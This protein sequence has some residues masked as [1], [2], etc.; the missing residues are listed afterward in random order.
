ML[1]HAD[2]RWSYNGFATVI[3]ANK[4]IRLVVVPSLGGKLLQLE[5]R[6]T[7]HEWLWQ[8][9]RIELEA[10]PIGAIFDHHWSGGADLFFPTCYPCTLHGVQIP[11]AGEMWNV[12]WQSTILSDEHGV[13]LV[14]QAG[15]RIFPYVAKRILRLEHDAQTISLHFE[16]CNIGHTPMPFVLGFHPALAVQP[17]QQIWLPPGS[18]EVLESGSEAMGVVGQTYVWP[19][20]MVGDHVYDMSEV[21]PR[22]LGL[23]GGHMFSPDPGQGLWW[24]ITDSWE[25]I[26]LKLNA[27]HQAFRYLWLWQVYGGWRGYEHL[28]LEPWTSKQL[29]L[30]EAIQENQADW[31][32]PG[33]TWQ[34]SLQFTLFHNVQQMQFAEIAAI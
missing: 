5:H 8:N 26:G 1:A 11:D 21:P 32:A 18:V 17:K 4:H 30:S 14:M 22:G 19:Y 6:P 10:A 29:T 3:L 23:Y 7:S 16:I 24:A 25:D 31:L 34:G 12:P 33:Q 2:T 27:D 15:G 13:S 28:A 20:V 9:E